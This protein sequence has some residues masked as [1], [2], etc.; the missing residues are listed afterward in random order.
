M[1]LIRVVHH[2]PEHVSSNS[3]K[4]KPSMDIVH[5]RFIFF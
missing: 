1:A 5:G 4:Q 2:D 3:N